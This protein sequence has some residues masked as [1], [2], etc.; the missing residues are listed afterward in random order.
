MVQLPL[1]EQLKK[2]ISSGRWDDLRTP[3]AT[4]SRTR[5]ESEKGSHLGEFLA[6]AS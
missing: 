3:T 1:K 4:R 5:M 6:P 2:D